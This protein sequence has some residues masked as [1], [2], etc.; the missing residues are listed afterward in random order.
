[1]RT[2]FLRTIVVV[3]MTESDIFFLGTFCYLELS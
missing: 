2:G 3:L 1:M